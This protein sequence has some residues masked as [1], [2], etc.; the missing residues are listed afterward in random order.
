MMYFAD[1]ISDNI[2]KREPE[3]YLI[4]VN[5]PIARSGTQQYLQDE[6]GQS[7][8][9]TVTVYRP[10]EEVFSEATMASF[11]GMPVTNDHP[12]AEEGVTVDNVQYLA[13]GHCQNIRRGTGKDKDL[14]IADLVIVDPQTIQDVMDG[15]REISCGYNYELHEED[16]KFIQ[17][18]I[19]GNHI[20]IVDKGRAGK[21]VS[22]KDSAPKTNPER[23]NR[24][25]KKTHNRILA[26]ML[27]KFA[28][29]AEPDELEEAVDAIEEITSEEVPAVQPPV[30]E[31]ETKDEG[32]DVIKM[33]LSRLDALEQKMNATDED[34]EEMDPLARLEQDLDEIEAQQA[35]AA[36]EE[37][38]EEIITPD[39]DPDEAESHFVPPEM[40][41]E[42]DEDE[43]IEVEEQM[44]TGP[45]ED[46]GPMSDG[47][48]T[49]DCNFNKKATDAARVALNAIK[50]V[51]ASV[52]PSQRKKA[53][54]A[55]VKQI[56]K[57]SGMN[58]KPTKNGYVA[59]K[60]RR[61]ASDS[62]TMRETDIGKAIMAKRNPHYK[63]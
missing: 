7:G 19:R 53:A 10:E 27:A 56:R 39:E 14:L 42:Q 31:E 59:L 50:P 1:R 6:I 30:V 11:E 46:C 12:D 44:G 52:P 57:A 55:A 28:V 49:K 17:R 36:E 32:E 26:K 35:P 16:G 15:K 62:N 13:K 38:T 41:N 20:A 33:I 5:V 29:D 2:H 25:M 58:A 43:D 3:G 60:S 8:E 34:P 24:T 40:I 37:E 21:R 45:L 22:I 51:I 18:K 9:K 4:C 54:D 48:G 23:R 47:C 61:K 63:K